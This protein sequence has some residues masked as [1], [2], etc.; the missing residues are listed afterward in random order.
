MTEHQIQQREQQRLHLVAQSDQ[1]RRLAALECAL[2]FEVNAHCAAKARITQLE[3]RIRQLETG[4]SG[5]EVC[6]IHGVEVFA[7]YEVIDGDVSVTSVHV[8]AG[9]DISRL[10]DAKDQDLLAGQIADALLEE[11]LE[12]QAADAIASWEDEQI[13]RRA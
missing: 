12:D 10:L 7:C 2:A 5:A 13:E 3:A 8:E 6:E 1:A 11:C 4:P 9:A